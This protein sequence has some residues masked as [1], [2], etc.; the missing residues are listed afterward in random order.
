MG[1][2]LDF[3]PNYRKR[4]YWTVALIIPFRSSEVEDFM[5][6]LKSNHNIEFKNSLTP[7]MFSFGYKFISN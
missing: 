6:D 3:R 5:D 7:V 1:L 4:E 2:G